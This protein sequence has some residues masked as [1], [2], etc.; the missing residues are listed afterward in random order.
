MAHF[1]L[2]TP[3]IVAL[4]C[5]TVYYTR[6]DNFD[7]HRTL[8]T[9]AKVSGLFRFWAQKLMWTDMY[10]LL[11]LIMSFPNDSWSIDGEESGDPVLVFTRQ[12]T[13]KEFEEFV[14]KSQKI[15]HLTLP[16]RIIPWNGQAARKAEFIRVAPEVYETLHLTAL[17]AGHVLFPNLVSMVVL[18]PCPELEPLYGQFGPNITDVDVHLN[19]WWKKN[20][21]CKTLLAHL[22][23]QNQDIRSVK[24]GLAPP[25]ILEAMI[26]ALPRL[27]RLITQSPLTIQSL[28]HL[29]GLKTLES[30]AFK[31][32]PSHHTS[33]WLGPLT[34]GYVQSLTCQCENIED[35]ILLLS[36]TSHCPLTHLDIE[37]IS[38]DVYLIFYGLRYIRSDMINDHDNSLS[39]LIR[40]QK[41]RPQKWLEL[42]RAVS[43]S[44]NRL[45]FL[46]LRIKECSTWHSDRSPLKF[47]SIEPLLAL[48]NL[49]ELAIDAAGG[50]SINQS[51]IANCMPKL[52][53]IDI[54]PPH[55]V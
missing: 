12:P 55:I 29:G 9:L 21:I 6:D 15:S 43:Q 10:S 42:T 41:T 23:R 19:L 2:Q 13:A 16:Q 45:S 49:C 47:D 44:V 54:T 26:R 17:A 46:S 20:I 33:E 30:L 8:A 40:Q 53:R 24:I 25:D 36:K 34:F 32:D 22:R 51:Y 18:D 52:K 50:I 35:A 39:P 7:R 31:L 3:D 37:F 28:R 38:D 27:Q 4:L 14:A 5:E 11:P 1:C 48:E